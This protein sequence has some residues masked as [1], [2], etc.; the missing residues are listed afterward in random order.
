MTLIEPGITMNNWT[1]E[2]AH[3]EPQSDSL[4][5]PLSVWEQIRT[6]LLTE[7]L[8]VQP[9]SGECGS[10]FK[11]RCEPTM[12]VEAPTPFIRT[13]VPGLISM[14]RFGITSFGDNL[15]ESEIPALIDLPR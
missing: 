10:M 13:V 3:P 5:A 11:M 14:E 6:E 1:V 7:L 15:A 9:M 4:I 2:F 12:M 8:S